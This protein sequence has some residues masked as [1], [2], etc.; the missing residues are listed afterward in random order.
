MKN[1]AIRLSENAF[2][3]ASTMPLSGTAL[4]NDTAILSKRQVWS[5]LDCQI[6]HYPGFLPPSE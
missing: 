3:Q 1:H 4:Q 2:D 5:N 6:R